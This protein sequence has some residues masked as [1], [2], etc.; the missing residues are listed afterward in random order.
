MDT[1]L[2]AMIFTCAVLAGIAFVIVRGEPGSGKDLAVV[3]N[4]KAEASVA[5]SA[6][7]F[8]LIGEDELFGSEDEST[9]ALLDSD[10]EAVEARKKLIEQELLQQAKGLEL[11]DTANDLQVVKSSF[12][13]KKKDTEVASISTSADDSQVKALKEELKSLRANEAKMRKKLLASEKNIKE[14]TKKLSRSSEKPS[15]GEQVD[16]GK[17]VQEKTKLTDLVANKDKKISQ[18]EKDLLSAEAKLTN[19]TGELRKENIELKSKVRLLDEEIA[20][21]GRQPKAGRKANARATPRPS[22][23][24]SVKRES[25]QPRSTSKIVTVK[26]LV[27]KA[28]LRTGPGSEHGVLQQM[29]KGVELLTETK[30]GDWYRVISPTGKRAFIS[31]KVV[32]MVGAESSLSQPKTIKKSR[33]KN[34]NKASRLAE[35]FKKAAK[36]SKTAT[37]DKSKSSKSPQGFVPFGED[38]DGKDLEKSV[39]E[40]IKKKLGK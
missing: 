22:T 20:A 34:S 5:T 19:L 35:A 23:T 13:A 9:T 27:P 24:S 18:L 33:P 8:G 12:K 7:E 28:N 36:E 6:S 31:A 3:N 40:R 14:M 4:V 15:S 10:K 38:A 29:P 30:I 2:K 17:L 11:N 16:V 1:K 26:V 21:L 32:K 39:F 25:A 37:V